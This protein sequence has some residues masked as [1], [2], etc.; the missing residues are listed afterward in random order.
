MDAA[1]SWMG[2]QF[3]CTPSELAYDNAWEQQRIQ[4]PNVSIVWQGRGSMYGNDPISQRPQCPC[5]GGYRFRVP[6]S[7]SLT[8]NSFMPSSF[9]QTDRGEQQDRPLQRCHC[10]TPPQHA[11]LHVALHVARDRRS[12]ISHC[13]HSEDVNQASEAIENLVV[14]VTMRL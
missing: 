13:E 14:E 2:E 6:P 7:G 10:R 1:E 3:I 12:E 5:E 4:R 9:V 11:A 8:A